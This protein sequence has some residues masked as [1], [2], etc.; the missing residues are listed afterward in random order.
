MSRWRD[1]KHKKSKINASEKTEEKSNLCLNI[2]SRLK[3]FLLDS[4]LITTPILYLVMYVIM[5]DGVGFSQD[6]ALGW[7]LILTFHF[8]IIILFWK[9][10]QQTPGLK[11]YDLAVVD[12]NNK[13]SITFFQ[14]LIRYNVTLICV[15]S[16]FLMF[17]PF[18]RK[19]KKT[20]QDIISNTIVINK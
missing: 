18:F 4:F 7:S 3:A 5:G 10:K 19:D 11:A 17:L 16:F 20:L 6:R 1:V 9:Y 12:N 8:P 13:N 2:A 14:A 15:I